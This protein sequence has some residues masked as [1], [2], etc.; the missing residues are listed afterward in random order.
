MDGL[1]L[2][3]GLDAY[4]RY[5]H[6]L[7]HNLLFGTLLTAAS[8]RWVGLK[9]RSLGLVVTAFLSHLVGDY[10]GSGPGWGLWPLLP[11]SRAYFMSPNAWDLVSWQ[12]IFIT[13]CALA[14]AWQ[15]ALRRGRT[16]LEFV[17]AG[18]ERTVVDTI[19]LRSAAVACAACSSRAAVRCQRCARPLCEG[20]VAS[21]QRLVARCRD[22]AAASA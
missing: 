5:H 21:R 7:A 8:V 22:C 6:L 16:P 18:L 4:G 14:V 20:H 10:W 13:L 2:L 12:N 19:Q 3:F 9:P 11:F 17:H 1:S 15:I